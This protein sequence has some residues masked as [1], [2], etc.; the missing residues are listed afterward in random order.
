MGNPTRWAGA[1]VAAALLAACSGGGGSDTPITNP[2]VQEVI[3]PPGANFSCTP[4]ELDVGE[5]RTALSGGNVCL[6]A[7]TTSEYML[8]G[9]YASTVG[10]AN[11]TVSV[12]GFGISTGASSG[13]STE[14]VPTHDKFT[15]LDGLTP[16]QTLEL[17]F[18][19]YERNVLQPRMAAARAAYRNRA[20]Y[21]AVPTTVG[22]AVTLNGSEGG[23]S[24]PNN[25]T[26][27]VVAVS[28]RAIVVA[29]DANPSGGFTSGEYSSIATTF[30]TLVDPL[31]RDAFGD[32]TD[33]DGNGH[34]ILF[35]TRT[36]N[37]LTPSGSEGVVEGF[38]NPRDLFPT[39]STAT[40]Q[41]C[42][43][44]NFGEMFYLLVPDPTGTINGNVRTKTAVTQ[45]SIAVVAHE[46]QHLINAA[47]R[48]YVND[49]EDFEEVW[50]NEGLS[51]IAEELLFY[52]TSGLSPRSNLDATAIRASQRRVDAFNQHQTGNFGRYIEFLKMPEKS[53]PYADN[54]SLSNRGA[55]WSFLR[56]AADRKATADGTIWKDLVNSRSVG[57]TNLTQ[58]FG[59]DVMS[60]FR[61]WS[62]SVYTDDK[63]TAASQYHQPSW[64]FRSI[65]PALGIS[66]YPLKV[67]PLS[68]GTALNST[69]T[70]GGSVYATF[71][72]AAGSNAGLSWSAGPNVTFSV[73][74]TK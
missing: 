41:G 50:M 59:S 29:D 36:V 52:R 66:T 11:S 40:L 35:Y 44:S 20:S 43:G 4:V 61:D 23:C 38:F 46:Y 33:I 10:T 56:Y 62:I 15:T 65:L 12:T 27:H 45:S 60:W 30:D 14:L 6:K 31:D 71:G 1:T 13:A 54:D 51:H 53:S 67:R 26:G 18:R 37:E 3:T 69:L 21:A 57:M 48:L 58:V 28:S 9:F 55:I 39:Q 8:T 74:R 68:N 32:P 19:A 72:V 24:N 42:A 70:G 2:P 34:V 7:G 17:S 47:R 16:R 5:V 64:N 73:V 63:V 49:A 25:R 22:A